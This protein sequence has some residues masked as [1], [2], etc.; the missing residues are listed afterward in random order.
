MSSTFTQFVRQF[1]VLAAALTLALGFSLIATAWTGPTGTPPNDN[2]A[3]P[4]NVG[5]NSQVKAGG[6]GVTNLVADQL[7]FGADCKSSW[8]QVVSAGVSSCE[9]CVRGGVS[10]GGYGSWQCKPFN[11]G[12][13]ASGAE[14]SNAGRGTTV[15]VEVR[16]E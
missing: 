9:I 4:I 13:A 12:V 10:N 5:A 3:P 6:L 14:S 2:A 7:C 16:C 11:G 15:E 1:T 8:P